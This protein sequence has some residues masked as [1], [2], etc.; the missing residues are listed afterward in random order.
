MTTSLSRAQVPISPLVTIIA[1]GKSLKTSNRDNL[2][3]KRSCLGSACAQTTLRL[4][5]VRQACLDQTIGRKQASMR[6]RRHLQIQISCFLPI[7]I[8]EIPNKET[9]WA[10]L[11][12]VRDLVLK[13]VDMAR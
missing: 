11:R 10:A 9:Q 3:K 5:G 7:S 13:V 12:L 8:P 4:V 6:A 1:H 2:K